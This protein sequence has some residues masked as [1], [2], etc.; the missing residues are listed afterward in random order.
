MTQSLTSEFDTA[1]PAHVPCMTRETHDS[2]W[3]PAI[4]DQTMD[5]IL[6][7]AGYDQ[8]IRQKIHTNLIE[9]CS[10]DAMRGAIFPD[11]IIKALDLLSHLPSAKTLCAHLIPKIPEQDTNFRHALSKWLIEKSPGQAQ[12]FH[13]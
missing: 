7:T 13:L 6:H 8:K 9:V 10:N 12:G 2:N 3:A 4:M 11:R 1:S 5:M